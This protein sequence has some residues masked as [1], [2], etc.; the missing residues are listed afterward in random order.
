VED[1]NLLTLEAEKEFDKWDPF[2]LVCKKT[3]ALHFSGYKSK[4]DVHTS[5]IQYKQIIDIHI[6]S[7]DLKPKEEIHFLAYRFIKLSPVSIRRMMCPLS[8]G[9]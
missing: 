7:H 9:T 3:P 5:A 8:C 1:Y 2:V 4:I 6:P